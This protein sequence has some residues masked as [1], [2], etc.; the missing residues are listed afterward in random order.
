MSLNQR[1]RSMNFLQSRTYLRME[2]YPTNLGFSNAN[3]E[4][5]RS[6]PL[7]FDSELPTI[8]ICITVTFLFF[9]YKSTSMLIIILS[10][11]RH[12][13]IVQARNSMGSVA[14]YTVTT[15]TVSSMD[16][17]NAILFLSTT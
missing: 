1:E 2:I 11:C 10:V 12:K 13:V 4:H 17:R 3:I 15:Y 6:K 8:F 16:I 14:T 5:S 7:G 9:L